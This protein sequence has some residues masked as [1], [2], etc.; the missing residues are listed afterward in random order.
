MTPVA[1]T[2]WLLRHRRYLG[3]SFAVAHFA[4][5]GAIVAM[6]RIMGASPPLHLAVLGGIWDLLLI[7]M[8]FTSFDRTAAFARPTSTNCP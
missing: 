2:A 3:V 1:S 7:A 8:V 4:H 6:A 5:F